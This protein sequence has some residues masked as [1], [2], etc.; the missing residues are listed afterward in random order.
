MRIAI[1]SRTANLPYFDA[2]RVCAI[3]VMADGPKM[4]MNKPGKTSKMVMIV[5]GIINQLV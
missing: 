4:M 3:I 5:S 1:S 2:D